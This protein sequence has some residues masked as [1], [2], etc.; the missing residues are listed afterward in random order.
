MKRRITAFLAA[1]VLFCCCAA[2]VCAGDV[3]PDSVYFQSCAILDY[4]GQAAILYDDYSGVMREAFR[5]MKAGENVA[6]GAR[7]EDLD[8][9]MALDG[10][11][12]K[13]IVDLYE[14]GVSLSV[15]APGEQ[16]ESAVFYTVDRPA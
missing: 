11:D 15:A 7:L 5:S 3:L 1:A 8:A 10:D 13:Y 12:T 14:N 4:E 2:S 16:E 9:L 6:P